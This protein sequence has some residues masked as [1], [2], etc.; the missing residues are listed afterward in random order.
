MGGAGVCQLVLALRLRAYS[1]ATG[2][3]EGSQSG[4]VGAGAADRMKAD[5][6]SSL[7]EVKTRRGS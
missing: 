6:Q 5:Q 2:K 1:A 4:C 7:S 3:R